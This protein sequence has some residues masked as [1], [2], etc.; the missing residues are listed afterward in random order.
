MSTV[1]SMRRG[2]RGQG[3]T[4]ALLAVAALSLCAQA[5]A[6]TGR[7]QHQALTVSQGSRTMAFSAARG[8]RPSTSG[9][10]QRVELSQIRS[11][12]AGDDI[13]ARLGRDWL[14][15][16]DRILRVRAERDVA[17]ETGL[18]QA[19]GASHRV[20]LRRETVVAPAGGHAAS[21]ADGQARLGQGETGWGRAARASQSL[22]RTLSQRIAGIEAAWGERRPDG[23][24][25]SVWADLVPARYLSRRG[26]R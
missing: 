9:D 23:D 7:L 12:A 8:Y 10:A 18:E 2:E 3:L 15:V 6:W 26:G 19:Y 5:I 16:D 22:A 1:A 13:V 24:W 21:D 14:R 17:P 25:L 20:T 11:P 4:E